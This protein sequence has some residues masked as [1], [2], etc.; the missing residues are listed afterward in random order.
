MHDQE[1]ELS[2][3]DRAAKPDPTFRGILVTDG[4]DLTLHRFQLRISPD[5]VESSGGGISLRQ[6]L[7][8]HWLS[9]AIDHLLAARSA[10][11]KLKEANEDGDNEALSSALEAEFR[12]SMQAMVASAVAL[13]ALYAAV[14]TR[15]T[16]PEAQVEAWRAKR[17]AR[18]RQMAEVFRLAFHLSPEK[19]KEARRILKEMTKYRGWALH[20]PADQ[21]AP[22]LHPDTGHGLEWRFVAFRYENALATVRMALSFLLVFSKHPSPATDALN[23]YCEA[24]AKAAEGLKRRWG[25]AYPEL[26]VD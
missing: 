3:D 5:G 6:D 21:Q 25:E 9:L 11:V 26:R 15:I 7:S 14:K 4:A 20:P 22:I 12:A 18:W 16:V 8:R 19:V 23:A 17:T 1:A 10:H 24:L 2:E 13:D